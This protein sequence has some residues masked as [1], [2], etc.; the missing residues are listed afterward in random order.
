VAAVCRASW[1]RPSRMPGLRSRRFHSLRSVRGL[2]GAPVWVA[3]SQ[4]PSV[5][6]CPH[7]AA[8]GPAGSCA[9][10]AADRAHRA[11]RRSGGLLATWFPLYR[12]A[13]ASRPLRTRCTQRETA[14]RCPGPLWSGA[15][16]CC[17]EAACSAALHAEILAHRCELL[18]EH[19]RPLRGHAHQVT[20]RD[21]RLVGDNVH[22]LS[23][24]PRDPPITAVDR[25]QAGATFR[26]CDDKSSWQRTAGTSPSPEPLPPTWWLRSEWNCRCRPD[27]LHAW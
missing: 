23:D 26:H 10:A 5:H 13:R 27:R 9:V 20:R 25:D 24:H 21:A 19:G 14:G 4:S 11:N 1:R 18:G 15:R 6:S 8:R 16:P 22:Q 12:I 2:V 3:N 17:R 7:E